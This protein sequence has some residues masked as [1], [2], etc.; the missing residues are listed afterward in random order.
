MKYMLTWGAL[1]LLGFAALFAYPSLA[2]GGVP[3]EAAGPVFLLPIGY[4][5]IMIGASGLF[6]TWSILG[7]APER[8]KA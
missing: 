1:C 4:L 8:Q 7:A 2:Q 3:G 6:L 5:A